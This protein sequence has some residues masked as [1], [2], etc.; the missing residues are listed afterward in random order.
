MVQLESVKNVK[1]SPSKFCA[2]YI[3]CHYT[4]MHT[5][6]IYEHICLNLSRQSIRSDY[7][8]AVSYVARWLNSSLVTGQ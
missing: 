6:S 2:S 4:P 1:I 3:V 7:T 8:V 5:E